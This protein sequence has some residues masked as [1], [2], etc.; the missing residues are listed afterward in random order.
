MSSIKFDA[1]LDVTKLEAGIKKSN[2][3]IG[4][5]AKNVEKAGSTADQ[6]INKMT[7]SVKNAIKE[8]KDL[9]K[10]IEKDVKQLQK[11]YD[12]ATAGRGKQ[13]AGNELRAAKKS[14]EEEQA[15]LLGMQKQQIAINNKEETSQLGI[16]NSLKHW[17][18]GL[19]TLGAVMKLTKGIIASTE[20]STQKFE[21]IIGAA[22][23]ATNYFFRAVASGD[24]G[25]LIAG[26]DK[27]AKAGMEYV[28]TMQRIANLRNEASIEESELNIR[29]G[30]LREKTY[31]K[32]SG[33]NAERRSALIE[34]I[35]LEK[36]IYDKKAELDEQSFNVTLRRISAQT[37][38]TE[39]EIKA[40]LKEY[41]SL[42]GV[43]EKGEQYN[44]IKKI[45]NKAG[46]SNEYYQQLLRERNALGANAE[47]AGEYAKRIGKVTQEERDA[48]TKLW[49]QINNDQAAFY[50]KTRRYGTQL[51]GVTAEMMQAWF[52]EIEE[53]NKLR[54][55]QQEKLT[56]IK[57]EIASL[58]KQGK[59]RDLEKLKNQ[60]DADI[61]KYKDS[62]EIK[63]ALTE[64]YALERHEVEMKYL[65]QLK[66]EYEKIAD[67]L[68]R[69][70]SG[71]GYTILDRA[72]TNSG[73]KPRTWGEKPVLAS[74]NAEANIER[75]LEKRE[76]IL[77][78]E[79][80]KQKFAADIVGY[81]AE[82][83]SILERQGL[84]SE[85]AA[86][87]FSAMAE[88]AAR[89]ASG[90]LIGAAMSI[91]SSLITNLAQTFPGTM[92]KETERLQA[93][94]E[95]INYLLEKQERI[96]ARSERKGG[97][98]KAYE[99][100]IGLIERQI[101]EY[102]ASI[103]KSEKYLDSWFKTAKGSE[104]A[105]DNIANLTK[106]VERLKAEL[107]DT[108]QVYDDFLTGGIT[109]T[110]I[111]DVII[112]G[113]KEGADRGTEYLND[114]LLESLMNV[115][116]AKILGPIFEDFSEF[117]AAAFE[118]GLTEEEKHQIEMRAKDIQRRYQGLWDSYMGE[119]DFG[120]MQQPGLSGAISA[121]MTEDTGSELAG[122]FRR[123]ADDSRLIRDY[124]KMGVDH[125]VMIERNTFNTVEELLKT[126]TKLDQ[127]I[128]NTKPV[129]AG[130]L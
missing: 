52:D 39:T 76:K 55:S 27:A 23:S 45:L 6:G 81:G 75:E 9:I 21:Q 17:A 41:S 93:K 89:F 3:T 42:E 105:H 4:E 19:M 84:L 100:K 107:E 26:M 43:I 65:E 2:Q 11:A 25:G 112:Q 116:K 44:D 57:G 70:T 49:V 108:E 95:E 10:S 67:E 79:E 125:L 61:L 114:M 78:I 59:E 47:K 37:G 1:S 109:E 62:Q 12:N 106:E 83:A 91:L 121:Q 104:K 16:V 113:F 130:E 32:E 72:I 86:E 22:T 110:A 64:K 128:T 119:F 63:L 20:T 46:L 50:S 117:I 34:M 90:D 66:K 71:A 54:E 51:A 101:A 102:E 69:L 31:S 35:D 38:V 53:D 73:G 99:D 88:T 5:W 118:N 97:Q 24:L 29:I 126:N 127:V 87:Q 96:I 30:E 85:E 74:S 98:G 115:F 124:N 8:Q 80:K 68:G 58:T 13:A 77:K 111:A 123:F 120:D 48:L 60:Y 103:A 94:I 122:L 56:T 36:Q 18:A 33:N 129:F 14:L 15:A 82:F 92:Q 28:E 40:L 7:N